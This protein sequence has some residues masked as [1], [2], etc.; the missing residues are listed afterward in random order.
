MEHDFQHRDAAGCGRCN[1]P[2]WFLELPEA[3]LDP[4]DCGLCSDCCTLIDTE[5]EELFNAI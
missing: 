1:N 3:E 5:F 2:E 4:Q